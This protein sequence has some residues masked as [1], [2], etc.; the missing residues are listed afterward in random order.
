MRDAYCGLQQLKED[1][2][3]DDKR[4]WKLRSNRTSKLQSAAGAE[5]KRFIAITFIWVLPNCA[6]PALEV[7]A[8]KSTPHALL[9]D[10]SLSSYCQLSNCG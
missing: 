3:G 8:N 4:L 9:P 7:I 5:D 2:N 10:S 1:V 6:L